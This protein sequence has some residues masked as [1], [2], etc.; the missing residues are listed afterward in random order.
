M[1]YRFE[2][3]NQGSGSLGLKKQ[4][5]S[6]KAYIFH[7]FRVDADHTFSYDSFIRFH[8]PTLWMRREIGHR[9]RSLQGFFQVYHH[10]WLDR[11]CSG[12]TILW[13]IG[14]KVIDSVILPSGDFAWCDWNF[15]SKWHYWQKEKLYLCFKQWIN[16]NNFY[17]SWN[18]FQSIISNVVRSNFMWFVWFWLSHP[19]LRNDRLILRW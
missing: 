1:G 19:N 13:K 10:K 17:H 15:S 12:L 14:F 18:F 3:P 2:Q 5:I 6:K 16:R 7:E 4:Q 9:D 11:H 8:E